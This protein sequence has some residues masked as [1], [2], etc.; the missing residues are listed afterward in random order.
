MSWH[1]VSCE[2][3]WSRDVTL[4]E[5]TDGRNPITIADAIRTRHFVDIKNGD[6]FVMTQRE[7]KYL[8]CGKT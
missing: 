3:S 8:E 5:G 7:E 1:C 4:H 2:L 6:C